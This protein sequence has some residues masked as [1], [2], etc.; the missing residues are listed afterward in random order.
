M[1]FVALLEYFDDPRI[2]EIYY[3]D[4]HQV[5]LRDTKETKEEKWYGISITIPRR[6]GAKE[7]RRK[8]M[9]E[10]EY[11]YPSLPRKSP[12]EDGGSEGKRPKDKG[13]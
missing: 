2:A 6:V 11:K 10:L 12:N 9:K 5:S 3:L 1:T 8:I 4:M 13:V 7:S